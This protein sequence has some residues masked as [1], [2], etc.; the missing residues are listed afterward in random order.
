M[1]PNPSVIPSVNAQANSGLQEAN[2]DSFVS[3]RGRSH[4]G[5]V[6][7][8]YLKEL[9]VDERLGFVRRQPRKMQVRIGQSDALHRVSA[10][11]AHA[12]IG[13]QAK[14]AALSS[15]VPVP[16]LRDRLGAMLSDKLSGSF[17][18]LWAPRGLY[19]VKVVWP[20][21]EVQFRGDWLSGTAVC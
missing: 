7:R 14:Q 15:P 1:K 18:S 13:C 17:S 8:G 16:M 10:S 12:A 9:D 21:I 5:D 2:P 19:L 3:R 11:D 6:P 20:Q 4:E